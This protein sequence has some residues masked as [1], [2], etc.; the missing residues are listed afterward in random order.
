[1]LKLPIALVLAVLCISS[2]V[3]S[4]EFSA[5]EKE[6]LRAGNVTLLKV[7]P[8]EREANSRFVTLA[9][10]IKATRDELWDV[11]IDKDTAAEFVDGVLES[12]VLKREPTRFLFEQRT[13]VGGPKGSYLYKLWYDLTPQEQITFSFAGG[14]I[15]N[16]EGCWWIL[17]SSEEGKVIV[18]YSLFIDPGI[19]APQPIVK[20]G[21]KKSMPGTI[22]SM[23]REVLRR[24]E[25][26]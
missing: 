1:M 15:K 22:A 6:S 21:M 18:V 17:E 16:I 12:E 23:Q 20:A 24:R 10:V 9:Q 11:L 25:V 4:Q 19:F 8:G 14:D 2:L 5:K 3:K 7:R 13:V 26:E